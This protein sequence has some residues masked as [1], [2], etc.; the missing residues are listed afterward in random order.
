M[1]NLYNCLVVKDIV[2]TIT[3]QCGSTTSSAAILILDKFISHYK[4]FH[5][6]SKVS[7]KGDFMGKLK[8]LSLFSGIGAFEKALEDLG[9][10]YELVG[11]SEI[12]KYA[13]TAYCA[14][15]NIDESLN[16][17]DVSKIDIK[18]IP[19]CDLITYGFP[20]QDISIA[21]QQKG[22]VKGKTR[23]G[24]LYEA[25]RII[26][27]KKPKYAIA[28]NVK[29]LVSKKFI[30]DFES[31]L[32]ELDN[33]GYNNYWK[34]LNAKDYGIPQNRERV[35]VISIRKDIDDGTFK[36]PEP[37]DSG[38]RLKDMLEDDVDEK[39]FLKNDRVVDLLSELDEKK[40]LTGEKFGADGTINN[41]DRRDISNCITAKYDAGIQ[42]YKQMS[43]VV[44]EPFI[45]G[46]RGRN[47]DNSSDHTT[48]RLEPNQKGIANTL[49]TVL[50]DNLVV[51]PNELQFVGG[52]GD[53]D[54]IGDDKK[55]SRNYPQGNRVYSI[56]GVACSQTANGG[57]LGGPTGLYLEEVDK[58]DN[59]QLIKVMDIPKEIL[60][61]NDRQRR[62]Y[63]PN[64]ISPAV[65]SRQD[66]AKIIQVND[67]KHFSQRVYSKEGISPTIAAGN[68]GGGKEPCK[69][70]CQEQEVLN[71]TEKSMPRIV[72]AVGD[73]GNHNYSVKDHVFT[74]VANPASD[75]QQM[76]FEEISSNELK[77]HSVLTGGKWNNI[78]ESARRVYDE[79]GISPTIPTCAGGNVEPKA[80]TNYRIR[81]LTPLECWRLMGFSDEDY[82][83]ARRSLEKT[84]YKG[85]DKSN[86][87]M[88]KM[89]GNSIVVNVLVEIYKNLF[90]SYLNEE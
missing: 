13:V 59:N 26:E 66:S 74:I 87:Q 57:G 36:F 79:N 64:G 82:W 15:H 71:D 32:E 9:I 24:L 14:I 72:Q 20:C 39:Y 80:Y 75:R 51:A 63:F 34:V 44:A 29:N 60:N 89:A 78:Y 21:G 28:E 67:P 38:L 49:T 69:I 58:D 73:R 55:L 43:M 6:V 54:R 48:Q 83:K 16:L 35:F 18:D 45:A 30:K 42:K 41:P 50:K 86:S 84:Y 90:R 52:I 85:K 33:Y 11:F 56:T 62:V 22:I 31:F 4:K 8:V 46:C 2:P 76:V 88:Y 27:G 5:N 10:D 70:L 3:T 77:L 81:K 19:D 65:L 25:L 1:F 68:N 61:G 17:E 47:S 37:F 40:L 23:S 12:D 53:N 7:Q